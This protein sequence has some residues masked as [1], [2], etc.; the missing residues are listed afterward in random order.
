VTDL[1]KVVG[2]VPT[3]VVLDLDLDDGELAEA[4]L[5]FFAQ[6]AS[7]D[8]WTL[9][10]YPEEYEAGEFAGAP[11]TWISGVAG[12]SAG[13]LVP[14]RPEPG[15]PPF[16]QGRAPAIDF[17]DVGQVIDTDTR[18]CVP[19]G[20]FGG[21]TVI[22]EWSPTAP[23]SGHQQKY[24]APRVGLARQLRNGVGCPVSVASGCQPRG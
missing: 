20:C 12:A 23:D 17:Y 1:V 2:G 19:V 22:D 15:T 3:R 11:S 21:V 10:E 6:D 13:V 18:L 14:G 24:Y 7:D 9:G 16:V 8:V 4:E 5:A